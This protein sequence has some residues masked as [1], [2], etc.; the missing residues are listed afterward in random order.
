MSANQEQLGMAIGDTARCWRNLL[1]ERLRPLGLSQARWMVLLL[2]SKRG[3]GVVQKALAEWLG[4]E[5]PTLV[6]ILDRMTEDGWIERRESATDRRAKTVHL[7]Q[8]SCAIIKQ[9]NK[10]AAQLRRELLADVTPADIE[11]CM[12]VLQ[13]IKHTAGRL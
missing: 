2:L 9:I 12:R 13:K 1:N 10:V 4:I 5:G 8:Q 3:D 11:A 7:T 6:R